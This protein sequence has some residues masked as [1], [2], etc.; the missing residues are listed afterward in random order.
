MI[1][2]SEK[3]YQYALERIE[4]LLPL[5]MDDT[6]ADDKNS[7]ESTIVSDIVKAYETAHYPIA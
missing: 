3:Q 4:E 6:P 5:M 7:I 2:I 1:E